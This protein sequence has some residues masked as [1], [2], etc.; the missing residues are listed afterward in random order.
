MSF[1]W[2]AI[3]AGASAVGML[4]LSATALGPRSASAQP[5]PPAR[6]FGTVTLNGQP[7]PNGA[8]VQAR[9]GTNNCGTGTVT[10]A[11]ATSNYV[12]DVASV[13][14]M[15]GCGTDG[16]TVT[17]TVS[18]APAA[19]TG[20]FQTGAFIS[21]NLVAT[22]ATATPT[23]TAT[24]TRTATATATATRTATATATATRTATATATPT[25][26]PTTAPI[27]PQRP[28]GTPAAQRPAAPA[29]PGGAAP[30]LPRTGAGM[31]GETS[32]GG[33]LALLGLALAAI[34]A[35]AGTVV[36]S[37]KSR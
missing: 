10:A 28:A 22:A 36:V 26:T 19:Q 8:T 12:V 37:R 16:A 3:V 20:T 35:G 23:A 30:A 2:K 25:R 14:T 1:S 31:V 24:A 17:F 34:A 6:F 13:S 9:V 32:T 15:P 5:T 29:A 18:G 11:G 33:S 27:T 7:A 4:A 21:L